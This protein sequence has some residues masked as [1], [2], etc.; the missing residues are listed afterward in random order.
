MNDSLPSSPSLMQPTAM[1]PT[2][3]S[4]PAVVR[5]AAECPVCL[6][7][8]DEEIHSATL[9]VRQWFREEVTKGFALTGLV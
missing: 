8:H 9:S 7:P 1:Q 6:G 2:A 5:R 4:R 3:D